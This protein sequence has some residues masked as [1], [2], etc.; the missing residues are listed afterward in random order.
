MSVSAINLS[1]VN[2][3]GGNKR[4]RALVSVLDDFGNPVSGA[5]VTG[6]FTGDYNE[7]VSAPTN[8]SGVAELLTVGTQKGNP[9]YQFCVDDMVDASLTY[10]PGS[11]AETC[12][13]D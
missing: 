6:T 3:G 12:D 2:V 1:V 7:T 5:T 9:D 4:G 10:D 13:T 11:N 8:G